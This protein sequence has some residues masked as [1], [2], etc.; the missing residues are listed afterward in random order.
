MPKT[1]SNLQV[2]ESCYTCMYCIDFIQINEVACW[3]YG[4]VRER[5]ECEGYESIEKE[6][7]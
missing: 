6:E 5:F 7:K 4:R 2:D 1:K 3:E